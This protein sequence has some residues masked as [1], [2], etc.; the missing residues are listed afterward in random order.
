[1]K[2]TKN[3][4]KNQQ[5]SHNDNVGSALSCSVIS[6][7]TSPSVVQAIFPSGSQSRLPSSHQTLSP[8]RPKSTRGTCTAS[9]SSSTSARRCAP[10]WARTAW[11][12][13]LRRLGTGGATRWASSWCCATPGWKVGSCH[14][15][16]CRIV[17]VV[18]GVVSTF[19]GP[20][21][22]AGGGAEGGVRQER[23]RPGVHGQQPQPQ[24]Q[25]LVL[26][27]GGRHPSHERSIGRD[28]MLVIK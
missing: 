7:S 19:R 24:R 13:P 27:S 4:T 17:P 18:T 6:N 15:P 25:A 21:V 2:K 5:Y 1:M 8:G 9:R 26:R 16:R 20:G 11:R 10:R 12:S 28:S 22:P 14:C 3:K 23:L